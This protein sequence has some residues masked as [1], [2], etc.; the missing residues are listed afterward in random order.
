VCKDDWSGVVVF[1]V[2]QMLLFL[3]LCAWKEEEDNTGDLFD[4]KIISGK[5]L[6]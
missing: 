2:T 1:V 5:H 6:C 3:L 4:V